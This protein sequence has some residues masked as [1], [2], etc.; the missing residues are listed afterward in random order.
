M[1][2]TPT[3]RVKK[4]VKSHC[5]CITDFCK[6][7]KKKITRFSCM[8]FAIFP[9]VRGLATKINKNKTLGNFVSLGKI[10]LSYTNF[11]VKKPKLHEFLK[12]KHSYKIWQVLVFSTQKVLLKWGNLQI[13]YCG[14]SKTKSCPILVSCKKFGWKIREDFCSRILCENK[15]WCCWTQA[16]ISQIFTVSKKN[17][18]L[19]SSIAPMEKKGSSKILNF[20]GEKRDW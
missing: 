3:K 8:T 13:L 16:N 5:K 17:L 20:G 6:K 14:I 11:V 18:L 10:Q 19:I 12:K 4:E 9:G 1:W 7:K 15:K 2:R